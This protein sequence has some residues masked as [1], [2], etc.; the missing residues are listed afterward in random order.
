MWQVADLYPFSFP[1]DLV[2][3]FKGFL[4]VKYTSFL[5]FMHIKL[6]PSK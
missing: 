4:I 6:E 3:I 5:V 2:T 1:P